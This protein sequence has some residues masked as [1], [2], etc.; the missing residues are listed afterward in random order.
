MDDKVVDAVI[1]VLSTATASEDGL[2]ML[3]SFECAFDFM[4]S[5]KTVPK[6]SMPVVL[7]ALS[8]WAFL[9]VGRML[10]VSNYIYRSECASCCCWCC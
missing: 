9:L 8:C 10:N 4:D 7:L 2:L 5:F 6:G 1:V 3:L